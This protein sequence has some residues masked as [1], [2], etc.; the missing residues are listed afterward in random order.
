MI[1]ATNP[2]ETSMIEIDKVGHEDED[3]VQASDPNNNG[4]LRSTS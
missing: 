3:W 2:V 1:S 4:A